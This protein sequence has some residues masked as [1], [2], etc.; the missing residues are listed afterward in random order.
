[1]VVPIRSPGQASQRRHEMQYEALTVHDLAMLLSSFITPELAEQVGLF[2]VDSLQGAKLVGRNGSGDYS[3]IAF[4]YFWTGETSPR[5]YRLRRDHPDLE[6]QANGAIKEKGKYL[7]PPGRGT[8]LYFVAGTSASWLSDT[9]LPIVITE[10]EK[11]TI[12]LYRLA[13]HDRLSPRFLPIGLPGVWNWRGRVGKTT[14][15]QGARRDLKGVIADLGRI[16]WHGRVVY[17]IFDANVATHESVR[18]ARQGLARELTQRKAEVRFVDVPSTAGVNGVDDLLGAEGPD[19]VL[20]LIAGGQPSETKSERKSQATKLVELASEVELFHTPDGEPYASCEVSGHLETWPVKSGGFRYWLIRR[21]YEIEGK[22]PAAQNLK[23]ALNVLSSRARF[24]GQ[25]REVRIRIAQHDGAIYIDLVDDV[26]GVVRVTAEGWQVIACADCHVC[27]YRTRGMLPLPQTGQSSGIEAL[28][29]LVNITDE[30]WPL[31]AGWLVACYR[32]DKAFP[33]LALHGEQGSAKSTTARI[34]RALVDPNKAGLRS[35]PKDERD[36]MI[37]PTNGWVVAL[38][39]L[40]R[41][42]PSLL[43]SR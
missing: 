28:R 36:L 30:Q 5:E 8:F 7:S 4:P 19:Y 26:W 35:Q 38:D 10:G 21:L 41:I 16:E 9:R 22:A 25:A 15:A 18:A 2:R 31:A 33:V 17:I 24:D 43:Y 39:N 1:M 37:A 42:P 11:K 29:R 23:D 13:F 34:L 20:G 12:A 14:D 32:P 27:F 6:Q 3:G 40:S